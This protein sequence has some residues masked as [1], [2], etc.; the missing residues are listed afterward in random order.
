MEPDSVTFRVPGPAGGK[1][2][3]R[4]VTNPRTGEMHVYTPDPGG[5]TE[6]VR[7]C[8]V[9]AGL[10]ERTGPVRVVA[11]VE[12]AMP[13]RMGLRQQHRQW[14]AYCEATPDT[15]NILAA[16]HDALNHVGYIDDR[17]VAETVIRRRWGYGHTL[18]VTVEYLDPAA[19][20]GRLAEIQEVLR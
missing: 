5:F 13:V 1:A 4:R 8:A 10:Q 3:P 16:V 12:R 7:E 11:D 15:A 9:A 19:R 17:Q 14:G 18:T 6:R 20:P 2:R